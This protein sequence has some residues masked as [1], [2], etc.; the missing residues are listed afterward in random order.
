VRGAALHACAHVAPSSPRLRPAART[1]AALANPR[2][3]VIFTLSLTLSL[4]TRQSLLRRVDELSRREPKS[5]GA[6]PP[7]N[8]AALD[9]LGSRVGASE[10]AAQS[11]ANQVAIGRDHLVLTR[12]ARSISPSQ[13]LAACVPFQVAQLQGALIEVAEKVD[14]QAAEARAGPSKETES[15]I[16]AL[17]A[18]VRGQPAVCQPV[19]ARPNACSG[20]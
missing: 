15:R 5:I 18:Q 2:L 1:R 12:R 16:A 7:V 8:T 11:L 14:G 9:A 4:C 6:A 13:Q 10:A 20:F 19:G 17:E 3:T